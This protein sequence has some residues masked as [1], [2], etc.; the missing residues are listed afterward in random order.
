[1]HTNEMT[2]YNHERNTFYRSHV[3][4]RFM[5]NN[6]G[7]LEMA[8]TILLS[9]GLPVC[10]NENNCLHVLCST[11]IMFHIRVVA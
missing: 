2:Y 9:H 3:S 5:L 6:T 11:D 7:I 1:M 10:I 8:T 4:I